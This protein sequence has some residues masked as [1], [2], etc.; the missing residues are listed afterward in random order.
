MV[1]VAEGLRG[2]L[3]PALPHMSLAAALGALVLLTALFCALG[4]R[5]FERRSIA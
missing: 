3:T 2:S 5:S 1:Y 4:L